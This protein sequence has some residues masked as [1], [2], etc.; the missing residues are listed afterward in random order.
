MQ[1][2]LCSLPTITASERALLI[3]TARSLNEW[4]NHA[5]ID[6]GCLKKPRGSSEGLLPG[7]DFDERGDVAGVLERHGWARTGRIGAVN[8]TTT[9]YWRRPGKNQGQSA[10]LIGGKIFYVFSSNAYPFDSGKAYGPFGVYAVLEHAGD[11]SRAA[12]E[13]SSQGYGTKRGKARGQYNNCESLTPTSDF[14]LTQLGLAERFANQH[15]ENVRYCQ[16][17]GWLVWDGKRWAPDTT[18]AIKR[19]AKATVRTLYIEAS[20]ESDTRK[21]KD[22]ADFGRRCE[23]RQNLEAMIALGQSEL[24]IPVTAEIFDRDIMLLNLENGA[25]N[26]KTGHLQAHNRDDYITKLAPVVY[27][28]DAAC[29]LWDAFLN[30]I[31][32]GNQNLIVFLQRLVGYSLT[33]STV[34][35]CFAVMHGKGANGKTTLLDTICG[36]LGD[37]AQTA[38]FTTFLTRKNDGGIPNDIARLRGARLVCAT[39]G[40]QG[41]ALAESAIKQLTGGDRVAARFL[42]REYFEFRPTFKILLGT[43]HKPRIKGTD[44]AIWRRVKLI[45]FTETIP[46]DRQDRK[47]PEKLRA[48]APGIL[49]WAV[50]GCLDWQREGLGIPD[51]VRTA[52]QAYRQEEDIVGQF[53]A[54]CCCAS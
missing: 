20:L 53:I 2:S 41:R 7:Q 8:G 9:E 49:A 32:Q 46:E 30:R 5:E 42:H 45:P 11:F 50:R 13:L 14:A 21:R 19:M 6:R 33:G 1:G 10:S 43:N 48:E 17:L 15:G 37:Y 25:L 4:I 51:E 23:A 12:Q 34:E 40:E 27:A 29:P 28:P 31:F 16:S 18:G 24:P 54:E 47:L 44:L 38:A 36:I 52:T 3:D 26:L 39:E 35:H 22:I